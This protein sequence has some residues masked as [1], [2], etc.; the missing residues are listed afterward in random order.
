MSLTSLNDSLSCP[1]R[2][3]IFLLIPLKRTLVHFS[4][5]KN[6]AI[7]D[8]AIPAL[9]ML[10]NLKLLILQGTQVDMGGLRRLASSIHSENRKLRIEIPL[11][12]QHYLGRK[13]L[14]LS[15]RLIKLLTEHHMVT[16]IHHHYLL[17]PVPPLLNKYDREDIWNLQ[18]VELRRNL[19]AHSAVNRAILTTG[20]KTEMRLRLSDVLMKRERDLMVKRMYEDGLLMIVGGHVI[21]GRLSFGII[22]DEIEESE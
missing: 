17:H 18:L 5:G 14:V 13:L 1:S 3:R 16:D 7:N 21:D 10:K 8:D 4:I 6:P 22:E 15:R 2:H 11:H 9:I 20:N 19:A 12:C